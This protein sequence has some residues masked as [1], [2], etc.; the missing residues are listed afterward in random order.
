MKEVIFLIEQD[1]HAIGSCIS[2]EI[3]NEWI[4]AYIVYTCSVLPIDPNELR[5]R[6]TTRSIPL[7]DK[8]H[9]A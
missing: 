1:A 9:K 5:G 4:D 7:L 3:A 8:V 6:L 2:Q